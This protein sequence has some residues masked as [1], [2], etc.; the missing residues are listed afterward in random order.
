MGKTTKARLNLTIDPDIYRDARR[1]FTAMDMNMSS[2]VELSLSQFM[3]T[4]RPLMP[5]LDEVER[6]EREPA[7]VKAAMRIWLAH[8]VGQE[9]SERHRVVEPGPPQS[10]TSD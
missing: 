7:D 6:G 5:L 1:V 4:V 10:T 9:L 3:E 2:F 8:S